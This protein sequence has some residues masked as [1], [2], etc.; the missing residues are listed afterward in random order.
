M[1]LGGDRTFGELDV[2]V[3]SQA[4]KS[5]QARLTPW[6]WLPL[7]VLGLGLALGVVLWAKWGFL[8]AF[9]ALMTFCF[10]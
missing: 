9:D 10:G 5:G 1:I 8:I 4:A 6:T 7:T 3:P 2:P